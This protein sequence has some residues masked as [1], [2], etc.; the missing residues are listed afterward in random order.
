MKRVRLAAGVVAAVVLAGGVVPLMAFFEALARPTLPVG[1]LGRRRPLRQQCE[2]HQQAQ[3][4]QR[5]PSAETPPRP[6]PVEHAYSEGLPRPR[7]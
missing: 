1:R 4:V 6:F 2:Q 3:R 7:S 5:R